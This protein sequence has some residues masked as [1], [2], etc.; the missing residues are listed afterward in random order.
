VNLGAQLLPAVQRSDWIQI[1]SFSFDA[2]N[3]G[4][5]SSTG[6]SAGKSPNASQIIVNP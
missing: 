6:G 3:A 1:D 5:S 2:T 4:G